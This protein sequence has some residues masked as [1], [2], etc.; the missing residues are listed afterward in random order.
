MLLH[1][2]S[3]R[4]YLIITKAEASIKHTLI[5]GMMM[6]QAIAKAHVK[7]STTNGVAT[8]SASGVAD[9]VAHAVVKVFAQAFAAVKAGSAASASTSKASA[10]G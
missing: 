7:V 9:L 10:S 6:V 4:R 1:T 5:R 2:I 3:I 8:A